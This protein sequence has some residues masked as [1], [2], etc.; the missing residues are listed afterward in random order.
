MSSKFYNSNTFRIDTAKNKVVA[1]IS[2]LIIFTIVFVLKNVFGNIIRIVFL[3]LLCGII[4]VCSAI[5]HRQ[6][7]FRA[8]IGCFLA[9]VAVTASV[10]FCF[11]IESNTLNSVM[12]K[13][14]GTVIVF[15]AFFFLFRALMLYDSSKFLKK[16]T[17]NR[18]LTCKNILFL[19]VLILVILLVQWMPFFP[20]GSSPDTIEQWNQIHGI[21]NYN[22]IHAIGHTIFL[23][24]LLSIYDDY[25]IVIVVHI[26]SILLLYLYFADF[27]YSHGLSFHFIGFVLSMSLIC[28]QP[29]TSA[30]YYPWKDSPSAICLAIITVIFAKFL[31]DGKVENRDAL[32]LGAALAGCYL[33]R[34][35]GIIA[36]IVCGIYFM[37]S[38][39]RRKLFKQLSSMAIAVIVPIILVNLYSSS[40]LNPV[41]INNGFSIQVFGSGISAVVNNDTLTDEELQRIDEVLPVDWMKENYYSP[42]SKNTL[43]WE[44][45]ACDEIIN[46]PNLEILNNEF[47]IKMGE[48]KLDVIKLYIN[49]IP[50]H[51]PTLINDI[52]GSTAIAWHVNSLFFVSSHIFIAVLFAFLKYK[53]R[54]QHNWWLVFMPC[55]CN[56]ASIMI[57]TIT[58]EIRYLLPSFLIAPFFVLYTV[59]IGNTTHINKITKHYN[60]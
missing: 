14:A 18:H 47:V 53:Y 33:F 37:I 17:D 13:I 3:Y 50:K 35:N 8:D 28:F 22:N 58:N 49:L 44:K 43:I 21:K 24:I 36:L 29:V 27:F 51:L 4:I 15:I 45:D 57:S 40:V 39:M 12:L 31:L 42:T 6:A 9:S 23:K 16:D 26:V 20:H 30:Y 54:L 48:N 55:L 10:F 1:L 11:I 2:L 60:R 32:G 7:F 5:N 59:L 41:D 52:L 46:N 19:S 25:I 56:T 34:H 38:F